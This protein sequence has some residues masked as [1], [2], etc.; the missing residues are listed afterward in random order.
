MFYHVR[1]IKPIMKVFNTNG[2]EI[3]LLR[4]LIVARDL[5]EGVD[6]LANIGFRRKAIFDESIIFSGTFGGVRDTLFTLFF[7]NSGAIEQVFI[8]I[9]MIEEWSAIHKEYLIFRRL[10]HRTTLFRID[11]QKGFA[12]PYKEGSGN[13]LE[14]IK[15]GSCHYISLYRY[16]KRLIGLSIGHNQK[17][18]HI[19]I[20]IV[21]T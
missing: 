19:L 4:R 21:P 15:S 12:H 14:A 7:D 13:E 5:E 3:K 2:E 8:S 20:T 11:S 18:P 16:R 10:L 1:T 9:P 6:I 17:R